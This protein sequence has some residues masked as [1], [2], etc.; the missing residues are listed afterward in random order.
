MAHLL[1]LEV[2]ERARLVASATE[3][4][5]TLKAQIQS[6]KD[7]AD[8]EIR[9][10]GDDKERLGEALALAEAQ[11]KSKFE[12]LTGLQGTLTKIQTEQNDET[13]QV[14]YK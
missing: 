12:Q 4:L 2:E 11:D 1:E 9:S 7:Q 14:R 8:L 3:R 6:E 10:F 13:N 5:E